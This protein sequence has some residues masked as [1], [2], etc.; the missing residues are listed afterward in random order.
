MHELPLVFFTVFGQTAV[1]LTIL[2]FISHK[3]HLCDDSVLK[4]SN[5]LA[6]ILMII[7]LVASMFH[8]GQ[9]MRAFNTLSGIG[10]SPMSN[11]I[12]LVGVFTA[13]LASTVLFNW[14]NKKT[15]QATLNLLIVPAGIAFIWS[16]T[17][18]YQ[19]NTVSNW[20]T[21]YTTFQMWMTVFIGGGACA[22]V[23]GAR[24]LGALTLLIGI[25][26]SL[27]FKPEYFAIITQNSSTLATAQL[28]FWG[29]QLLCLAIG[30][31]I[32]GIAIA[33]P[34]PY[35][36]VFTFGA[37]IVLIGEL[38]ARIAFYNLWSVMP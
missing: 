18:V 4:K 30:A 16:I 36:I 12:V 9:P 34:Q 19:L 24:K 26:L 7:A 33:R 5:W 20:N 6:L 35:Q 13:L 1:G 27:F 22:M 28:R 15:L 14:L 17:Q 10:H 32:A 2:A 11:E 21:P 3:M 37:I 31:F 38:A 25:A 8:L 23:I 29:L